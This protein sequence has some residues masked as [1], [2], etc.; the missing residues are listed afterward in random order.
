[1]TENDS[2][3]DRMAAALT[4]VALL[5]AGRNDT[6]VDAL[7]GDL[8]ER[9]IF[10]VMGTLTWMGI[11]MADQIADMTGSTRDDVFDCLRAEIIN[12]FQNTQEGN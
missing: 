2:P 8:G 10:H 7:A 3:T 4:A 5:E 11:L 6:A 9:D 1:M 12:R